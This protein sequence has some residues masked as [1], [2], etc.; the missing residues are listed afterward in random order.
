MLKRF[1][2]KI[3]LKQQSRIMCS[4]NIEKRTYFSSE[5][6]PTCCEAKSGNSWSTIC[7]LSLRH[8]SSASL[9]V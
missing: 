3:N 6:Q 5:T 2:N 8:L 1:E 9:C 4:S 7:R